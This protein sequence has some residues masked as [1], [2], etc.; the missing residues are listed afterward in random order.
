M[1]DDTPTL[2]NYE[3]TADVEFDLSDEEI[4]RET[5]NAEL[6]RLFSS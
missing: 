2:N 6:E 4:D 3:E 1:A 5:I